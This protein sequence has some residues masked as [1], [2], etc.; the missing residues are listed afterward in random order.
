MKKYITEYSHNELIQTIIGMGAKKF[1][2][3]Q[4]WE[5][6]YK[7]GVHDFS[8]MSNLSAKLR[9]QLV[10]NFDYYPITLAE[11]QVATDGTQK[12]LF[13][14]QDGEK[15]E[16]VLIPEPNRATVC[17]SS[18]VGCKFGC[19]FCATGK[20]GFTRNLTTAEIVSQLMLMQEHT[21]QRISNVV[22][23]GMGEPLD[24]YDN[25]MKAAAIFADD[26]ALGMGFR[27]ITVSTIGVK[28]GLR[29]FIDEDIR[30][31]L[32]ISLHSPFQDERL[33]MMPGTARLPLV[34][35]F[36]LLDEYG[37]ISNR[38]IFFEYILLHEVNDRAQDVRELKKLLSPLPCKLNLIRFHNHPDSE[39]KCSSADRQEKFFRS[40]GGVQFPVVFR[41]SRGEE[42]SAACGQLSLNSKKMQDSLN[43]D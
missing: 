36:E 13:K 26:N 24:N 25:V 34:E 39:F 5:W 7:K 18:Q 23:M 22:F 17:L 12:F 38:K 4:I 27:K 16:S 9:E 10:D 37:A 32:A 42:I 19:K 14:M 40:F 3:K 6:F 15:I 28:E 1:A 20:L 30:Y 33:S 2:A 21:E 29:R 41:S 11:K 43:N 31:H 8:Q 35:L